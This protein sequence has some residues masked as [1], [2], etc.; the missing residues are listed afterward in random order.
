MKRAIGISITVLI[1]VLL[2]GLWAGC[3]SEDASEEGSEGSTTASDTES[4]DAE[5]EGA[6]SEDVGAFYEGK[7]VTIVVPFGPGGGYDTYARLVAQYMEEELQTTVI[8]RNMAGG[9]GYVSSRY[10]YNA[11]P[12]GLTMLIANCQTLLLNQMIGADVA[13]GLDA[14]EYEWLGR[15]TAESAVL[16]VGKKSG[17]E[18]VDD[19]RGAE[20][21]KLG[22][23]T[24]GD[25][26]QMTGSV[27][28]ETLG[29]DGEVVVGFVGTP[30]IAM[31]TM[32]G[33]LDGFGITAGSGKEFAEQPELSM[34]VAVSRE[35]STLVPDLP[36]LEEAAGLDG[37]EMKWVDA[38]DTVTGGGRAFVTTP[39]VPEERVQFL[40]TALAN[41]LA[42]EDLLAQ[43]AK[44]DR[45]VNYASGEQMATNV[46]DLLS[47]PEDEVKEIEEVLM[48]KYVRE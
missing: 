38:L 35:K 39:G 3:A 34:L 25:R 28:L 46:N 8:V 32:K 5:S 26:T 21:L 17:I 15:V 11:E 41:V 7:T 18:T 1:M 43:A 12:N 42:N 9:Q 48:Y 6:Q 16:I 22:G 10:V 27:V 23:L 44:I 45:P 47:L 31:A 13:E 29:L 37:E 2:V 40:R 19:L 4:Q 33:E 20:N 36:T 24:L 14:R 30:A